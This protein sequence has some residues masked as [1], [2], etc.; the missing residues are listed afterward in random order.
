MNTFKA[1]ID[2]GYGRVFAYKLTVISDYTISVGGPLMPPHPLTICFC[3]CG[4]F[5]DLAGNK[6]EMY[7]VNF[8]QARRKYDQ[9]FNKTAK[10]TDLVIWE[11]V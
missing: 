9:C 5:E 6:F 4:R 10:N 1:T 7:A 8:L 2:V 3:L 11:K